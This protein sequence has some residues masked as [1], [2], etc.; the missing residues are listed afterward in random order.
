[1][2]TI[3]SLRRK[4]P[5]AWSGPSKCGLEKPAD[6]LSRVR[7]KLVAAKARSGLSWEELFVQSDR[8]KTGTLSYKELTIMVREILKVPL[9]TVCEHD[10][11]VLF[12][13][14][15]EEGTS[16]LNLAVLL[17]YLQQG[18]KRPEDEEARLKQ[19]VTRVQRNV[20]MA[21]CKIRGDEEEIRKIFDVADLDD[22]NRLSPFEFNSFVRNDLALSKWHVMDSDVKGVY[23]TFDK[24]GQGIDFMEFLGS[25]RQAGQKRDE[26]GPQNFCKPSSTCEAAKSRR[27][28]QT[29]RQ[30]LDARLN[31]SQAQ[32]LSI[33]STS[34]L[35][36]WQPSSSGRGGKAP[37]SG[38]DI[39]EERIERCRTSSA[40]LHDATF[41]RVGRDRRAT[42]R[43]SLSLSAFP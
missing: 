8:S 19:R 24:D 9:H 21:L 20:H 42:T 12:T 2:S 1:M 23:R 6:V 39:P 36:T 17:K 30:Q 35:D 27:R 28:H 10:L 43:H 37:L 26:C 40:S 34:A 32:P 4:Q 18:Y 16:A 22:S 29:Y 14:A 5:V 25:I 31:Q 11:K 7:R 33:R 3:P 41:A 15:D 38:R 13:E